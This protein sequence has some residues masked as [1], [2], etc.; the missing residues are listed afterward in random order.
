MREELNIKEK[1]V[2]DFIKKQVIKNGYAPTVRE[3]CDA[4]GIKST[5]TVYNHMITLKKKGY[6][7]YETKRSRTL[8]LIK[9]SKDELS[10]LEIKDKMID[11]M[12]ETTLDIFDGLT[13]YDKICRPK[14]CNIDYERDRCLNCIK[15]HYR[16]E[17]LKDE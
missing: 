15:E 1:A 17:V 3:I 14:E 10:E 11:K 5:A 16:K 2:F 9:E 12:A 6:I 7:Q 4:T 8:K 13:I